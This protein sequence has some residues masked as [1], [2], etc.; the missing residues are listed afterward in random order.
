MSRITIP[1]SLLE[2][3]EGGNTIWIH[4]P[5]GATILRLKAKKITVQRGCQN[6]CA[7]TDIMVDDVVDFCLPDKKK[8]CRNG[9]SSRSRTRPGTVSS[10]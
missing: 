3:D 7:H 2:F 1:V 6:I 4:G 10:S 8:P 9:N 5:D